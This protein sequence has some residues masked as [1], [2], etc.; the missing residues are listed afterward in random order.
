MKAEHVCGGGVCNG[1]ISDFTLW[2]SELC[3]E[4]REEPPPPPPPSPHTHTRKKE[5]ELTA[6]Q[7]RAVELACSS[8]R[9]VVITGGPGTGKST[10]LKRVHEEL[11]RMNVPHQF[12]A[13]TGTAARVVA[14][15]LDDPSSATTSASVMTVAKFMK[16]HTAV[17]RVRGHGVVIVDE[18]SMLTLEEWAELD[19]GT[20]A[21][22]YVLVGD[23]DQ[24][25]PVPRGDGT[26]QTPMFR[27]LV[28]YAEEEVVPTARLTRDFRQPEGSA[29]MANVRKLR[30]PARGH[31]AMTKR[32][33]STADASFRFM[34]TFDAWLADWRRSSSSG[35]KDDEQPPPPL[36][37]VGSN[38]TRAALNARMQREV[39]P[40]GARVVT[41]DTHDEPVCVG[42]PVIC[43][44]NTYDYRRGGRHASGDLP[45]VANGAIG[46]M[47]RDG[48]DDGSG[49]FVARFDGF[50]DRL[51][52]KTNTFR[53]R[54]VPAYAIT[55]TKSQG[56]GFPT[57]VVVLDRSFV[58]SL[59]WF[60]TAV[61][62][63]SRSCVVVGAV[64]DGDLARFTTRAGN[65]HAD[66]LSTALD[67]RK[68][69]RKTPA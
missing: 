61:S 13:P 55:V 50:E 48:N 39:N 41:T 32:D 38:A 28:D 46:R 68:R 4:G 59:E 29:L 12:L 34:D 31:R 49:T 66:E 21:R 36:I 54:F 23:R 16:T 22:R 69:A 17:D 67:A 44:E 5:M 65:V 6:E 2:G 56:Q 19:R 52:K 11:S 10:V 63:A 25:K 15:A 53:T 8:T 57:V 35:G 14:A 37:L 9:L 64:H 33:F 26:A 51:D 40:N 62:R 7:L 1:A 27:T 58:P 18:A 60:Y 42:D 24:L 3:C 20:E 30:D 43:L 45:V 47:C